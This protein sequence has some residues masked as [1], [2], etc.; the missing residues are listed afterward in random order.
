VHTLNR[1]VA[2]SPPE[3]TT[4]D[5]LTSAS[6]LR[7]IV[8]G[9]SLLLAA[10]VFGNGMNY[11]FML[12]LAR[13]LG[14]EEFGLYA[15]GITI[16]NTLVLLVTTG[17]DSG[18]VK[19]VS[20]RLAFDD[21]AGARRIAVGAWLTATGAGGVLAVGLILA[22]T[23]VASSL[24]GK[25]GL[26]PVLSFLSAAIPCAIGTAVLLSVFQAYQTVRYTVLVKYLW[27]PLSKWGGAAL[28]LAAGW[29]L[30]GVVGSLAA[31]LLLS[32]ALAAMLLVRSARI[33][34]HDVATISWTDVRSLALFCLPLLGA[35]VFG[36]IAPRMDVMLL[37]YW[38]SSVDVGR[39]LVAFQTAAVLA[40]VLGAFDVVFAPLMSRAWST[41]DEVAMRDSYQA[42]HRMA[43]MATM[44]IFVS[45]VV[46]REEVLAV[47]GGATGEAAT[48]LSILAVGHLVNAM[49]GGSSTV[50][51]MTGRSRIVL[52][53]TI[54]YGIGL[55]L[56]AALMIPRWGIVGAAVAASAALVGVNLMRVWQ[57]WQRHAVLPWTW[58]TVKPLAA[59]LAMGLLLWLAKPYLSLAWYIPLAGMGVAA[60]LTLLYAFQLNEDD[61]VVVAATLG[62][63]RPV[64]S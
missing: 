27:E 63:L 24:Y 52:L 18:A 33:T 2:V 47:F 38:A 41:H 60:Y 7:G 53:N 39:Y 22:A 42:V 3:R 14:M 29:G 61:R 6:R 17:V 30:V 31:M 48:A 20:D 8:E 1:T 49:T 4:S 37:G 32:A 51:L 25:P 56:G 16:F 36:I 13:H 19:F 28:A 59:G 9:G 46:F 64:R 58:Q 34:R 10:S 50:L 40:L 15:L 45:V 35:N 11:L 54:V 12:F 62:R 55:G 57:V 21:H 43:S 23:P 44:P 26:A 5:G